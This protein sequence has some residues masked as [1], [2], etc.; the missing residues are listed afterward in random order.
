M[1]SC[2]RFIFGI[3]LLKVISSVNIEP[4][5]SFYSAPQCSHCKRCT[6]YGISVHL[7]VH[8]SV[9]LS[10]RRWYC[11]KTTARRMVHFAVSDS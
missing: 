6:S 10:L 8:L 2:L 11:V 7:S 1:T 5:F 4:Q 9:Y 3:V